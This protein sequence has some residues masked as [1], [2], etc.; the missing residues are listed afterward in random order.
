MTTREDASALVRRMQECFNSR[1]FDEAADLH[2]PGFFSHP[3]GTTGFEAGKAAWRTLVAR[4][5]GMRVVA[6]DILVDGD[7]A[8]V[9]STVEG[10]SA[11]DG[12]AKPVL[13]EIFRFEDGRFA[14]IWGASTGFPH[15]NSPEE[16]LAG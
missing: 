6:Q 14:E 13:F 16:L 10:L 5:P 11:A 2:T 9:R 4:Y 3:L 7:R 15:S 8:A 1:R 12:D